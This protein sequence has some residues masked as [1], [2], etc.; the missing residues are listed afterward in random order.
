MRHELPSGAP[1]FESAVASSL[2]PLQTTRTPAAA[3]L[4]CG[5][6]PGQRGF[7]VD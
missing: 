5:A 2:V 4:R 6:Y 7:Q 1:R 3:G